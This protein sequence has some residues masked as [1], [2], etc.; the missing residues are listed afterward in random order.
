LG[1]ERER[2]TTASSPSSRWHA[3]RSVRL[4]LRLRNLVV[5]AV[6]IP[7]ILAC[8]NVT[9]LE[10]PLASALQIYVHFS[11]AL[12]PGT[13]TTVSVGVSD[14][15]GNPVALKGSQRLTINGITIPEQDAGQIQR[16]GPPNPATI[17]RVAAGAN[18]YLFTYDDGHGHQTAVRIPAPR[19][20][21]ALLQPAAGSQVPLPRPVQARGTG[22][23]PTATLATPVSGGPRPPALADTPLTMRYGLP[24]LL[25]DLPV[26]A[27]TGDGYPAGL[28]RYTI[29]FHLTG[30]CGS[31][32]VYCGVFSVDGDATATHGRTVPTGTWSIDDRGTGWG[33]GFETLVAG[34]GAIEALADV[35]W[36]VPATG[37]NG[38][39]V[40]LSDTVRAPIT[41]VQG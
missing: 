11:G 33:S 13:T 15:Y 9:T 31:H 16:M 30:V 24:Y 28:D 6:F 36:Q 17:A 26:S 23:Q 40:E 20:D 2:S 19:T 18:A 12:I 32:W 7:V 3:H 35:Q 41:W 25:D 34:P 5:A 27:S 4:R 39:L 38:F 14:Q 10:N 22:G 37:F 8:T 21:F 29:R 1:R